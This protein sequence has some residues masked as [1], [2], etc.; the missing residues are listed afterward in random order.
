M[1]SNKAPG[2]DSITKEMLTPIWYPLCKLLSDFFTLCYTWA[3]TPSLWRSAMVLPIY[4]KG[5]HTVPANYR[6]ISLTVTFRK[7]Y[8]RCL[9][10]A[11]LHHMPALDVAQG[12]FRS[13]CGSVDQT[14]NLVALQQRFKQQHGMDPALAMLDIA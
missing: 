1:P 7:L 3:W 10:P 11:L 6:P 14:L 5:D 4:K 8:E 2:K 12:G 13:S 9:Q